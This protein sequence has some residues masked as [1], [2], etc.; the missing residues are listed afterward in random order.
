MATGSI[1]TPQTV[2]LRPGDEASGHCSEC[3]NY[4]AKAQ[5]CNVL[6]IATDPTMLCDLYVEKPGVMEQTFG[7][8][9]A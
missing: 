5:F 9:Y 1:I 6:Q 4:D 2:N 7:E 3:S 8:R